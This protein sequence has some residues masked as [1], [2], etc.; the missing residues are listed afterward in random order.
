MK[1]PKLGDDGIPS[2]GDSI[3][4]AMIR[5]EWHRRLKYDDLDTSVRVAGGCEAR[6]KSDWTHLVYRYGSIPVNVFSRVG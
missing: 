1:I 2:Q 3:I 6:Q 4:C 5:G